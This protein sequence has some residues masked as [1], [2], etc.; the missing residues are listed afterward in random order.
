MAFHKVRNLPEAWQAWDYPFLTNRRF[1]FW[2]H[3]C[4]GSTHPSFFWLVSVSKL[5]TSPTW[6][7]WESMQSTM[8]T[9]I[10]SSRSHHWSFCGQFL[11]FLLGYSSAR[12]RG[13][14]KRLSTSW[15]PGSFMFC[16]I[17]L[18]C[19]PH[20]G[21]HILQ[22]HCNGIISNSDHFF[23]M[24]TRKMHRRQALRP[25]SSRSPTFAKPKPLSEFHAC[26]ES[27]VNIFLVVF[28]WIKFSALE[29]TADGNNLPEGNL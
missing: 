26:S 24:K 2:L 3:H 6:G 21:P 4:T 29:W 22:P 14:W 23:P 8:W 5:K 20:R 12:Q 25:K 7:R 27:H 28:T 19:I 11:M 10:S 17:Y 16:H 13:E 18:T 1:S 9:K 15:T